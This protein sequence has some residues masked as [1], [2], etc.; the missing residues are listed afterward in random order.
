M[1][2]KTMKAIGVFI[3]EKRKQKSLTQ[4]ILAE[5]ASCNIRT[6]QRIEA[7]TVTTYLHNIYPI[8]SILNISHE[9][10]DSMCYGKDIRMFY[11]D[12][13]RIWDMGLVKSYNVMSKMIVKLKE[14]YGELDRPTIKQAMLLL[15]GAVLCDEAKDYSASLVA[16]FEA[17]KLTTVGII[18]DKHVINY[19]K[20]GDRIFSLYEYRILRFIANLYA[21][22]DEPKKSFE[23][24][25][26][27]ATSLEKDT[28]NYGVQK[29]L[30][31]VMYFSLSNGM[32]D[33]G[34]YANALALTEKGLHFCYQ[35]KEFKHLGNLLW[36]NGKALYY[37]GNTDKATT[38]FQESYN[39]FIS[40]KEYDTANHLQATARDKYNVILR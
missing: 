23:L 16:M 27:I 10:F 12:V 19:R 30:M 18:S 15:E 26:A 39:F 9:E 3:K 22:L 28:N 32:I 34:D 8:L 35:T 24:D 37:L 1:D 17:L 38:S 11:S 6:L 29:R 36:N 20:V 25:K 14:E 13:E 7:G 31:P 5:M 33:D 2:E 21:L 4:K 40:K